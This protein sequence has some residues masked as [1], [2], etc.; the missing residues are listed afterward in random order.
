MVVIEQHSMRDASKFESEIEMRIEEL[1][2]I[3]FAPTS[4]LH[5]TIIAAACFAFKTHQTRIKNSWTH[6]TEI[7]RGTNQQ[8]NYCYQTRKIKYCTHTCLGC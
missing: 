3:T 4:G 1:K 5:D 8:Q 2:S 7:C 6:F